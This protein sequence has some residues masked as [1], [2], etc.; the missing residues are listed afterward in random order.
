MAQAGIP[1]TPVK[2]GDFITSIGDFFGDVAK[3]TGVV[4]GDVVHAI[5]VAGKTVIGAVVPFVAMNDVPALKAYFM[6]GG[7][8]NPL[9]IVTVLAAA[10][11][12]GLVSLAGKSP[13]NMV[14]SASKLVTPEEVTKISTEIA[15]KV[16][17][18]TTPAKTN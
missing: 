5:G 7:A 14:S 1:A 8:I 18:A 13:D 9:G 15:Q 6:A 3:G 12:T 10:T 4:A 11:I 2:K 17:A 16:V